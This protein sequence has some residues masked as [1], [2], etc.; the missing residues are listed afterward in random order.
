MPETAPDFKHIAIVMHPNL[1]GGCEEAELITSFL[2]ERGVAEVVASSINE[3]NL[4]ERVKKGNFNLLISLG[5]DGTVLRA[6]HLAAPAGIPVLGINLGRSGFLME[7]GRL[8]WKDYLPRLFNGKYRL[9]ERML[10]TATHLRGSQKLGEWDVVNEV[11]VCRGQHVRPINLTASVDGYPLAGYLAD[12]LIVATPTGSTAYALAVGGPVMPPELR[13][14]LIV[15]VAPHLSLDRAI[16][17]P[18]TVKVEV[19]VHS[20]HEVVLSVDGQAPQ[21]MENDDL[22]QV[23]LNKHSVQFVRFLDRGAFYRSITC[24]MER[25]SCPG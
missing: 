11:V 25:N 1:A 7:V 22:V 4:R 12:G 16:I 17:L 24:S 3:E 18:E 15:P 13:S 14:I 21:I 9:E 19:R 5:G 8:D 10:L 23:T 20:R 2:K 6:A